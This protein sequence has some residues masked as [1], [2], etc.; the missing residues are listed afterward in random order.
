MPSPTVAGTYTVFITIRSH[1]HIYN[2]LAVLY[3]T[4]LTLEEF[5]IFLPNRNRA[6]KHGH[7]INPCSSMIL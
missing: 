5:K 1:E 7:S 4:S 3:P 6:G 2:L